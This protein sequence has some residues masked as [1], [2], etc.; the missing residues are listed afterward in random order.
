VSQGGA[1]ILD[2]RGVRKRLGAAQV[3]DGVSLHVE[4]GELVTLL[5]E[6]G[7]GKTTLLRLCA[8]FLRPD[9][10]EIW[11]GGERV[12]ALPPYRRRVNTVFQHYALFPHMS[13]AEN[14][15]YGLRVTGVPRDEATSRAA[16]AL[17]L[18][19]MDGFAAAAP[20]R[21]SGGQQQRVA[22]ARALVN[23]PLL[24]L[25]DEPLSA[26]DA[27][28]RRQMQEELV[29][30][31]REVGIAFVFVTHDQ[32]EALALSDRIVLLR[33]GKIEQVGTPQEI[34]ERPA[35]SYTARFIGQTNL[36]RCQAEAGRLRLS[37]VAL[38]PAPAGMQDG[39][40]LLSL[41]PERLR[42]AGPG[43]ASA[44][45][46][47][48]KAQVI[49]RVYQGA[50]VLLHLRGP[51]GLPLLCRVPAESA[52]GEGEGESTFEFSPGDAVPVRES[53]A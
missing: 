48:L 26:L 31:Q 52:P 17:A 27:G 30:L 6:S 34:Y 39:P 24:L 43:A 13:V 35:T 42:P 45:A 22:L 3:L 28:L 36:L 49:G 15:A 47:R 14:V 40:V 50:T 41:R 53:A 5:G 9:E 7:S 20:A 44:E 21:L 12:D 10:G 37:G 8:G 18:V 23:R 38:G 51:G 25:L 32:E 1:P 19:K 33:G 46:V 2:I 11:I 29:A 16:Q 4:R